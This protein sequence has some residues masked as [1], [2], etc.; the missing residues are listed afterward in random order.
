MEPVDDEMHMVG[1]ANLYHG[2]V[3][4]ERLCGWSA[5]AE[6]DE[7][8]RDV[9]EQVRGQVVAHVRERQAAQR[10][11]AAGGPDSPAAPA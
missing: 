10:A 9:V 11:A 1:F 2:E 6:P 5:S 4:G 8:L 3:Y 7:P